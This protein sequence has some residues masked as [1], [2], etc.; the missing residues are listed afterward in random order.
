MGVCVL[1][2]TPQSSHT[3]IITQSRKEKVGDK[4][5]TDMIS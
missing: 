2:S 1:D 4:A 3:E 5:I